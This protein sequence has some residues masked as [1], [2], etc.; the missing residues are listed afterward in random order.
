M[1][2]AEGK[3]EASGKKEGK[4]EEDGSCLVPVGDSLGDSGLHT[5]PRFCK[6]TLLSTVES[7]ATV[8]LP[9]TPQ[10]NSLY[11]KPYFL[12][13]SDVPVN[14]AWTSKQRFQQK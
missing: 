11:L 4:G 13:S 8:H 5:I 7:G 3:E 14:E 10:I 1:L 12:S 9:K 6:T 2:S